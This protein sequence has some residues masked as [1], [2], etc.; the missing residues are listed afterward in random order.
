MFKSNGPVF[1]GIEKAISPFYNLLANRYA[2]YYHESS[3]CANEIT[4]YEVCFNR[5][6]FDMD[7]PSPRIKGALYIES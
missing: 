6:T 3:S 5:H 1:T 7:I 2:S 4:Y